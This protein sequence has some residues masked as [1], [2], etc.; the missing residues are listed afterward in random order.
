MSGEK[1][2]MLVFC[3]III[4]VLSMG[5]IFS[6]NVSTSEVKS[7]GIAR[8]SKEL[9]NRA[10]MGMQFAVAN[11]NK[12]YENNDGSGNAIYFGGD[13]GVLFSG[14][15]G[16]GYD[17]SLGL[18]SLE[19]KLPPL[20]DSFVKFDFSLNPGAENPVLLAHVE[21]RPIL[22]DPNIVVGQYTDAEGGQRSYL[23][24]AANNIEPLAHVGPCPPSF[25]PEKYK[26][27]RYAI[28]STAYDDTGTQLTGVNVQVGMSVASEI[29]KVSLFLND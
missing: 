15:V 2:S 16:T 21:V 3:I 24:D 1:G 22:S 19:S 14:T 23:S 26:T 25:D 8:Q 18:E 28:T 10:E 27:R 11:F 5:A 20:S 9:F 6:L 4:L 12:I 29:D 7:A 13:G 17:M